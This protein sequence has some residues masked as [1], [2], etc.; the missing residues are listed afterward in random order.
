MAF[1]F[2]RNIIKLP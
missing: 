2:C 1:E